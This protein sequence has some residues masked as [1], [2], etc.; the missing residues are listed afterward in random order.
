MTQVM[1]SSVSDIEAL[2]PS[3]R[4]SLESENK[5]S[6]TLMG[7]G[8]ATTQF[9]TFLPEKGRPTDVTAIHRE[10]VEAFLKEKR[11]KTSAA[12][13]E[14]RYRGLR[15]FFGWC[16]SEVRSRRRRWLG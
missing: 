13:A 12:T 10:H 8:Y 5:S 4:L 14:A 6:A 3:W 1:A 7:Y 2:A 9:V 11:E 16:E 15:Q